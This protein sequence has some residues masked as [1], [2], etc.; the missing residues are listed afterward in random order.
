MGREHCKSKL[1]FRDRNMWFPEASGHWFPEEGGEKVLKGWTR[2][3]EWD[4]TYLAQVPTSLGL[5]GGGHCLPISVGQPLL[6][7]GG[8]PLL[9]SRDPCSQH[10]SCSIRNKLL[11]LP[12]SLVQ[13]MPPTKVSLWPNAPLPRS[14]DVCEERGVTST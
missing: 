9:P 14:G 8:L 2:W 12:I 1:S 5:V 11:F 13:L 6:D 10:V 3:G 7:P 4:K